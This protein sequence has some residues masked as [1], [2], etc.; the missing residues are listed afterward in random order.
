MALNFWP[1]LQVSQSQ[2]ITFLV[3]KFWRDGG[4]FHLFSPP[5]TLIQEGLKSIIFDN[6]SVLELNFD[7]VKQGWIFI[8]YFPLHICI[9]NMFKN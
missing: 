9:W 4:G 5:S 8:F 6:I 1:S 7:I 2:Q 3:F